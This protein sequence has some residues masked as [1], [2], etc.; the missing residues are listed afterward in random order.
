[1]VERFSKALL[2]ARN[3]SVSAPNLLTEAQKLKLYALCQQASKGPPSSEPPSDNLPE[4][5]R[6][7]WEA[8]HDVR[9]ISNQQAME[10]YSQIIENLEALVRESM[11]SP[12]PQ[13]Q[14]EDGRGEPVRRTAADDAVYD[15]EE[16]DE[17]EDGEEGDDY[18]DE[19]DEDEP[20]EEEDEED[21]LALRLVAQEV[22]PKVTATVWSTRSTS[23]GAGDMLDVP[24]SF[25]ATSRCT[26]S[27][28][29]VAGSGPVG[30]R[31][32][33]V[34]PQ[35][36]PLLDLY[37]SSAEG[38]LEVLGPAVLMATLD[39]TAAMMS[40]VELQCR[41]CLE[42]IAELA[43]E[44]RYKER[45]ATH[46]RLVERTAAVGDLAEAARTQR[47]AVDDAAGRLDEL[48]RAVSSTRAE[49]HE[50]VSALR[51]AKEQQRVCKGEIRTLKRTLREQVSQQ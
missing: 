11:P 20:D 40:S 28:S 36:A 49:L 19:D 8:W 25:D 30:F 24:L 18:Y 31:I 41:V 12:V 15:D 5:D 44:A 17:D 48:R 43:E 23:V 3:L 45:Q 35:P 42:P 9:G 26:Y 34:P 29:I 51:S 46:E 50:L 6:A 37:E 14:W 2:V 32:N 1:M 33:T 22:P 47:E 27:F 7:K 38:T 10:S 21:E 13:P 39:N 16:E 4:L